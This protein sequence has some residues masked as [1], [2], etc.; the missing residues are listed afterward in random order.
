MSIEIGAPE[1]NPYTYE[2]SGCSSN[3]T[4]FIVEFDQ[5]PDG[6]TYLLSFLNS[7]E[8]EVMRIECH[9]FTE[10]LVF[11]EDNNDWIKSVKNVNIICKEVT[12]ININHISVTFG[13]ETYKFNF[14]N[15]HYTM[16]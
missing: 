4:C 9:R 8:K 6:K 1:F 13:A 15:I 11:Y 7:Q 5:P 3:G 10:R 2:K 14:N 16:L 12:N